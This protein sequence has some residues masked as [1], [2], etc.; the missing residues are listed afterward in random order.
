MKRIGN[1]IA[2]LLLLALVAYGAVYLYLWLRV[3]QDLNQF[4]AQIEPFATLDYGGI[5]IGPTGTISVHDLTLAPSMLGLSMAQSQGGTMPL[6]GGVWLR[7][8]RI[9][10]RTPGLYYVLGG[11]SEDLRR[12]KLPE[13]LSLAFT[14]VRMDR[15]LAAMLRAMTPAKPPAN[16]LAC[17]FTS[18]IDMRDRAEVLVPAELVV[19]SELG[20]ERRPDGAFLYF[21]I[22]QRG[23]SRLSLE[24]TLDIDSLAS[25]MVEQPAFK[26]FAVTYALDPLY[27]ADAKRLCAQGSEI[28]EDAFTA[29]LVEQSD[30]AYMNDLGVIPGPGLRKALA[31]ALAG[32]ELRAEA[33]PPSYIKPEYLSLYAPE[34]LPAV[35]GLRL[36]VDGSEVEDMS[37][38]IERTALSR[39]PT[40][41]RPPEAEAAPAQPARRPQPSGEIG[42]DQLA[43]CLGCEVVISLNSG[44]QRRGTVDAVEAQVVHVKRRLHGGNM[45]VEIGRQEIQSIRAL[46]AAR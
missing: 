33:R 12:G 11:A 35:L 31:S 30:S 44:Q 40:P 23:L 37:F 36:S 6:A 8:D 17:N 39:A 26:G 2:F 13:R 1:A 24:T 21:D 41:P 43:E 18:L 20:L 4:A 45:T 34:Q 3:R 42:F 16:G 9:D 28:D 29:A 5:S 10:L 46:G 14:G 32:A 15:D 19:D 38:A 22:E 27:L 7:V 25:V